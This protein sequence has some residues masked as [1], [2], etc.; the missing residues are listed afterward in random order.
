MIIYHLTQ[1]AKKIVAETNVSVLYSLWQGSPSNA[2]P[3]LTKTVPVGH[4]VI[5]HRSTVHSYIINNSYIRIGATDTGLN[6][7][8]GQLS[9][10]ETGLTDLIRVEGRMLSGH[11]LLNWRMTW[12]VNW[13]VTLR[14]HCH[15]P[16]SALTQ[17]LSLTS[18]L[19]LCFYVQ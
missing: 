5:H 14:K 15:T 18:V 17:V 16:V 1:R 9:I 6:N 3:Q 7:A 10:H 8:L 13:G 19:S 12:Q 11:G 2:N 4:I